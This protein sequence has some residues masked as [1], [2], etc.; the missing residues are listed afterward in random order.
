MNNLELVNQLRQVSLDQ[1][2]RALN[3]LQQKSPNDYQ[4]VVKFIGSLK[5]EP[6]FKT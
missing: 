5:E 4:I 1:F 2:H 6:K 3:K